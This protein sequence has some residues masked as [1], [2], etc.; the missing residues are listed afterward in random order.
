VCYCVIDMIIL[1]ICLL[2]YYMC[3]IV[4]TSASVA[5]NCVHSQ[6]DSLVD[7]DACG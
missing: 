5:M 4:W 1:I 2:Q 6:I 7:N 3:C